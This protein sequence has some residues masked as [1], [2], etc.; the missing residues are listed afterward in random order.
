M[1]YM[2]IERFKPG[3]A[4]EIYRRTR[5]RGRMLPEGLAY[6]DSWVAESLDVC[7]QLMECEDE[8]LFA[9]WTARWADL[10][11]FEIVPVI[12]SAE[13]SEKALG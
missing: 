13:A 3:A 2:I 10:A 7:Y 5:D 12:A 4:T 11:D 9:E 6:I 8:S 1:R